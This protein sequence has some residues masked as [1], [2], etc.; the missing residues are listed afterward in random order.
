MKNYLLAAIIL[1]CIIIW[2]QH[3]T[4]AAGDRKPVIETSIN[5]QKIKYEVLTYQID[6][7]IEKM[8]HRMDSINQISR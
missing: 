8:K 2:P 7:G 5:Y 6:K 3:P 1:L 4:D